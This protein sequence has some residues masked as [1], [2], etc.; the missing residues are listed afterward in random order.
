MDLRGKPQPAA[1]HLPTFLKLTRDAQLNTS[2]QYST[3]TFLLA[4]TYFDEFPL[5]NAVLGEGGEAANAPAEV[6]LDALQLLGATCFL[7]A[8]KFNEHVAPRL[9]QL[10]EA[11]AGAY[12]ADDLRSMEHIILHRRGELKNYWCGLHHRPGDS[13]FCRGSRP[14]QY[15]YFP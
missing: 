1:L 10:I 12:S 3:E 5:E 13:A 2:F 4:V 7:L 8:A 11:S 6:P 14:L 15:I 9:S